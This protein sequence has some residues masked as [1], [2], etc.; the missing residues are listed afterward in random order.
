MFVVAKL[1]S[2]CCDDDS[3]SRYL[4][5]SVVVATIRSFAAAPAARRQR[6]VLAI[7]APPPTSSSTAAPAWQARRRGLKPSARPPATVQQ[8]V[9]TNAASKFVFPN[10][11]VRGPASRPREGVGKHR[12][13]R[14]H[15]RAACSERGASVSGQTERRRHRFARELVG[16]IH[17]RRGWRTIAQHRCLHRHCQRPREPVPSNRHLQTSA[18]HAHGWILNI[19]NL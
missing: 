4:R 6:R 3:D 5:R 12:G 15:R 16:A 7:A 1:T 19:S 11:S 2:C 14:C 10:R 9:V 17:R 18:S 13:A 8:V